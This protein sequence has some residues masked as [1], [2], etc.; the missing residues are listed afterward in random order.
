[1]QRNIQIKHPSNEGWWELGGWGQEGDC[2]VYLCI[3]YR[4][5]G[6]ITYSNKI[7]FGIFQGK[8]SK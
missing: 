7:M 5:C 2:T 8:L 6:C 1:L 3:L 4:T